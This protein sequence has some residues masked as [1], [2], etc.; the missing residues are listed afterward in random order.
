LSDSTK[1]LLQA[2][3]AFTQS[4]VLPDAGVVFQNGVILN[5]GKEAALRTKHPDADVID[6]GDSILLPGL[7]NAHTHL[8]L[9]NC[10]HDPPCSSFP[11]WIVSLPKRIGPDRNFASAT[12]G[13][14]DQCMRFGVTTIGDISQQT[15]ITRQILAQSPLCAVSYGEVL[16][17]STMKSRYAELLSMALDCSHATA[18]LHIGLTPHSPYT[19]DLPSFRLCLQIAQQARLRLA[20]HLAELPYEEEFLRHQAGPLRELY[21]RLGKWE[22]P[23]QTFDGP[24]IRFAHEI[25]LLDYPTLLAHVNYCTDE[26]LELLARGNASVVYCPRTHRYFG[27]PPHRFRDMLAHGINVALGTDSCASS[28]DLNLLDELRLVHQISPEIPAEK[29]FELITLNAARALLL[30]DEVGS[31]TPGKRADFTIFPAGSGN[32]VGLLES[33]ALPREIWISG[34]RINPSD[35][36]VSTG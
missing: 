17:L 15:H 3:F 21:E 31:L 6:A 29:L 12:Q 8:E 1:T 30:E 22:D 9:S 23:V 13:G 5:V 32:L 35:N 14:I 34:Q 19:I 25:G 20:T 11:D 27:H 16:G 10:S 26:E 2:A 28:P 4:S 33:Q 36:P 18:R 24:P 7:I